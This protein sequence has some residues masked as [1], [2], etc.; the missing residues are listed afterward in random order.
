M[1]K[2]VAK[3]AKA[4]KFQVFVGKELKAESNFQQDALK[5]LGELQKVNYAEIKMVNHEAKISHLYKKGRY[6]KNY[7]VTATQY[8]AP[9]EAVCEEVVAE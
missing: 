4:K 5:E 1:K 3:T 7:R 9:S 2:E 6:D 8:V